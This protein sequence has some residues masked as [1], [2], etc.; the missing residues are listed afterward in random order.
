MLSSE[1][2]TLGDHV[3]KFYQADVRDWRRLRPVCAIGATLDVFRE[4]P[5]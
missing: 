5:I 2:R 3:P 4:L 1:R